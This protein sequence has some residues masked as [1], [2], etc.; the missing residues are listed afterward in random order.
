MN[1]NELTFHKA[2]KL[3]ALKMIG[4]LIELSGDIA[5]IRRSLPECSDQDRSY[6]VTHYNEA[7]NQFY[8]SA[9][10]LTLTSAVTMFYRDTT[11]NQD[12]QLLQEKIK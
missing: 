10:D 8:W 3:A 4:F 5:L 7:T 11:G 2:N 6:V 1:I 9:Y 12:Y